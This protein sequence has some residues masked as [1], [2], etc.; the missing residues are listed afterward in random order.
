MDGPEYTVEDVACDQDTPINAIENLEKYQLDRASKPPK[1]ALFFKEQE[2]VFQLKKDESLAFKGDAYATLMARKEERHRAQ[3]TPLSTKAAE[4]FRTA[5]DNRVL[6]EKKLG[7]TINNAAF[8]DSVF[9]INAL[10]D[11]AGIEPST[12][13]GVAPFRANTSQNERVQKALG[14]K[15]IVLQPAHFF[16]SN[17]GDFD[18]PLITT[19]SLSR[20]LLTEAGTKKADAKRA[21]IDRANKKHNYKH[22]KKLSDRDYNSICKEDSRQKCTRHHGGPLGRYVVT[23]KRSS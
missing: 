16:N 8:L 11:Y 20:D 18:F 6:L 23:I 3:P 4:Y 17:S 21:S 10:F 1:K 13:K 2:C 5:T 22:P 15:P 12:Y 19:Q 14:L 7:F 9:D